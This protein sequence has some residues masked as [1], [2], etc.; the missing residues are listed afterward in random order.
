[1]ARRRSVNFIKAQLRRIRQARR[2]DLRNFYFK[3]YRSSVFAFRLG[4]GGWYR[5][6]RKSY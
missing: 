2:Y 4:P 3:P 6:K 5:Q 1:M